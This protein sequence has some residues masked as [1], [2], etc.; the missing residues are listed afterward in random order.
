MKSRSTRIAKKALCFQM[1]KD[2][3]CYKMC[4]SDTLLDLVRLP[5][6]SVYA[7]TNLHIKMCLFFGD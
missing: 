2:T 3:L 4:I 6:V 7:G 1:S 5:G